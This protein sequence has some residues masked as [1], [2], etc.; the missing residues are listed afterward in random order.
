MSNNAS[1]AIDRLFTA[2]PLADAMAVLRPTTFRTEA[3]HVK[4]I[5]APPEIL[6]GLWLY[7][8]DLE[9]SHTLAQALDPP[10]GAWWHAIVHRREGDFWNSK[11]WYRRVGDHPAMQSLQGFN[12]SEFV[13]AAEAAN[14]N[15]EDLIELQ[16]KE[17]KV[18]FDWCLTQTS[19]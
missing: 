14:G 15:P 5:E 3:I 11:Y 7:V 1:S 16:R 19:T 6:A 12:P 17:W 8:D 10:T 18:L 4:S 13:D 2:L 9:H